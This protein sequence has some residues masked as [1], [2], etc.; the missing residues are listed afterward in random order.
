MSTIDLVKT[1]LWPVLRKPA[2]RIRSL[3]VV[4][5]KWR[6]LDNRRGLRELARLPTTPTPGEGDL[7]AELRANGIARRA[8]TE[9]LDR[10]ETVDE[11][12]ALVADIEASRRD[13]IDALRQQADQV[14]VHKNYVID[15]LALGEPLAPDSPLVRLAADPAVIRVAAGY[16]GVM[17][18]LR[19]VNVWR[20]FRTASA[21]RRAQLW[22]QD[23]EDRHILK[24]FVY[25]DDVD[26]GAGP[27]HYATGTNRKR[28]L[29][30]YP[31]ETRFEHDRGHRSTD[32]QMDA[33]LP[34]ERWTVAT[35]PKGT[36]AFVDTAGFHKGGEARDRERLVF[37]AM[38]LS[39]ASKYRRLC[40][41]RA[42][43]DEPSLVRVALEGNPVREPGSDGRQAAEA[44]FVA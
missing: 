27:L 15:L 11:V 28:L 22:H 37:T 25:L 26:E 12:L 41:T 34:R 5:L 13:E 39:P 7:V 36:I 42:P 2:R 20:S 32:T 40:L 3:R 23:P 29:R 16:F 19:F 9:L 6:H 8:A 14:G 18:R 17:P 30:R 31:R 44:G 33:A 24:V 43:Q 10:P 1:K 35:G 21:P 38:Y 4:Q